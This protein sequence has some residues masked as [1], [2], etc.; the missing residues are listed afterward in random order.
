MEAPTL[1]GCR[2]EAARRLAVTP[3]MLDVQVLQEGKRGL[4]TVRPFRVRAQ[5]R[6]AAGAP[7]EAGPQADVSSAFLAKLDV[8]VKIARAA[9]QQLDVLQSGD[10]GRALDEI[11]ASFDSLS[12][13]R[14]T[15]VT[16]LSK[17]LSG[18]L[19][20][21]VQ[22]RLAKD[23]WFVIKVSADRMAAHL[24]V[25]PPEGVGRPVALQAVLARLRDE[26]VVQGVDP[27]AIRKVLEE[28]VGLGQP[29]TGFRAARAVLPETGFDGCVDFL[30]D[31]GGKQE[32]VRS[33]GSMDYR[34]RAGITMVKAGQVLARLVPPTPGTPGIDVCGREIPAESG[35]PASLAIG[36]GVAFD[37]GT[38]EYRATLDGL[39]DT[40]EGALRVRRTFLV[41]GDVDM[42]TGNIEFDGAVQVMGSV[43][44]GFAVRASGD[45]EV[46]GRVEGCEILSERGRVLVRQ[47]IAGRNRCFVSAGSDVEAKYI[48]NARVYA[49]RNVSVDVAVMHSEVVAGGSVTA[50]RGRGSLIGGTIKAGEAVIAK[51]LGAPNEP[52]TDIQVGIGIEQQDAIRRMDQRLVAAQSAAHRLEEVVKEFEHAAKDIQKLPARE[53]E[54]YLDLRKKLL[55]LH[56]EVDKLEAQRRELI[57]KATADARGTV[58]VMCEAHGRV[59]VRIGQLIDRVEST[60]GPTCFRVDPESGRIVRNR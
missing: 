43:H 15:E 33:D 51:T 57:D 52:F 22:E 31:P 12:D 36:E 29:V 35:K 5:G 4:F 37:A 42:S 20:A 48:E 9:L 11:L 34:G 21:K 19:A 27:D 14:R 59:V 55:V 7:S 2:A 6:S 47:G 56:Y 1:D 32:V 30:V 25:H 45:I 40:S 13:E 53:R 24:D 17:L 38:G 46:R 28:V 41:R 39:L 60:T 23:G 58:R 54:S 10:E 16:E 49:R 44:D 3:E 8:R 50:T 26:G 18:P